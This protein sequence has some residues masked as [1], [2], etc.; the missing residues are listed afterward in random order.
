MIKYYMKPDSNIPPQYAYCVGEDTDILWDAKTCIEVPPQPSVNHEYNIIEKKWVLNE[1][2]YMI[3][4]RG[5]R[6]PELYDTDKY[7]LA[8]FPIS[9]IDRK[10]MLEYRQQ[11]RDCPNHK[12]IKDRKMPKRIKINEGKPERFVK[13]SMG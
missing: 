2:L 13:K 8:D 1:K 4:L 11:L 5:I 6:D 12:D 9:V 7:V 10:K 3:H